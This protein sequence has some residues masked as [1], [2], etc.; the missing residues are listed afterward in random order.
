MSAGPTSTASFERFKVRPCEAT[1]RAYGDGS[2]HWTISATGSSVKLHKP[3]FLPQTGQGFA[4][5][6]R[7]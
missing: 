6:P 1:S 4:I 3:A 2:P 5:G 7:A